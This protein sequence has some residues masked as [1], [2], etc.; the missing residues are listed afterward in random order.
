MHEGGCNCGA[1][2]F[3][4]KS[5]PQRTSVCHCKFCQRRTGSAFGLG[6]YFLKDDFELLKGELRAYEHR[7]D[8]SGRWLR[9][10]FCPTCGS[11]V[12]WTLEASPNWRGVSGGA[13]DD[14][15]WLKVERHGWT[16]SRQHWV[17]IPPG[18]ETFEKSSLK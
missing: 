9:T 6:A 1:V 8:E 11:T 13:F 10:E 16:R 7:S 17:V 5:A 15:T 18:V 14:T 4:V 12:T 2:R 3:R